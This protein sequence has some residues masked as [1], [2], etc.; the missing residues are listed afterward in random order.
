MAKAKK[1]KKRDEGT[2]KN[3]N[4]IKVAILVACILLITPLTIIAYER[5]EKNY[6]LISINELT[7]NGA[8]GEK[9]LLRD[10]KITF[11][12]GEKEWKLIE[13]PIS[14]FD[15]STNNIRIEIDSEVQ[16]GNLTL[17]FI[18]KDNDTWEYPGWKLQKGRNTATLSLKDYSFI[19]EIVN[20]RGLLNIT[21]IRFRLATTGEEGGII[22]K[23]VAY[24]RSPRDF[25]V[26]PMPEKRFFYEN[27]RNTYPEQKENNT[28]RIATLG[29]SMVY[30]CTSCQIE[31]GHI[32]NESQIFTT[33][34]ENAINQQHSQKVEVLNFGSPS[35]NTELEVDLFENKVQNYKPDL[36]IIFF[37]NND[38]EN[39]KKEQEIIKD[40]WNSE[41]YRQLYLNQPDT[42]ELHMILFNEAYYEY[43]EKHGGYN[44][45]KNITP[46]LEQ[47][48]RLKRL[49]NGTR[50]AIVTFYDTESGFQ[51]ELERL[52]SEESI[53]LLSLNYL[54]EKYGPKQIYVCPNLSKPDTHPSLFAQKI[55]AERLYQFLE[56]NALLPD[57][58]EGARKTGKTGDDR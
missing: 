28:Y 22:V 42:F 13:V 53:P 16:D 4:R 32:L 38:V 10:L 31:N 51:A 48:K 1:V 41:K 29:D 47:L 20:Q 39:T 12:S 43:L 23:K 34:L 2:G 45:L 54:T 18:E 52:A 33:L 6:P 7:G 8:N 3:E 5:I 56:K 19:T 40:I 50:L 21:R 14:E 55:I 30:G 49:T 17:D 46:V 58:M 24:F 15:I 25:L 9:T 35:Y 37:Y 11:S 44:D 26:F 57:G 36:T 27:Y